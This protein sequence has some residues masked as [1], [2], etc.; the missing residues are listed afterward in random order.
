MEYSRRNQKGTFY[1]HLPLTTRQD[2][3][4]PVTVFI[5]NIKSNPEKLPFA[6]NS[7]KRAK[8]IRFPD[9]LKFIDGCESESQIIIGTEQVEPL[10]SIL[11]NDLDVNLVRL[12]LYKISSTIK[13]LAEDCKMIHGTI[14]IHSVYV[15]RSGEW[16]L[17]GFETLQ[18]IQEE[19]FLKT[20]RH[21]LPLDVPLAPELDYENNTPTSAVDFWLLG[22][23]IFSI[24]NGSIK[25]RMELE[26]GNRNQIPIVLF[27]HYKGLVA[28]NPASRLDVARFLKFTTASKGYFDDDFI[29]TSLFLEQLALKDKAEKENFLL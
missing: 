10:K 18:P 24:F 25:N 17:G 9:C 21:I 12:G 13:F 7:L 11:F 4:Q 23:L 22:C 29:A 27:R 16:K 3:Q 14:S 20:H 1:N 6:R 2:D 19:S 8:T 15:T 26:S 28:S 5:F